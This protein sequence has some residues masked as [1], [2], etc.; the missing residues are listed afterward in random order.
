MSASAA[1]ALSTRLLHW[2]GAVAIL[3]M[4]A[5]GFT[6]VNLVSEPG[7]RFDLYQFPQVAW[8]LRSF[9][10]ALARSLAFGAL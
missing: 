9:A 5:L 7:R 4:L 3:Y 2:L 8:S 6:M 10:D 1:W